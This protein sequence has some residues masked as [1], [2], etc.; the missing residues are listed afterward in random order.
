MKGRSVLKHLRRIGGAIA[1]VQ[2]TRRSCRAEHEV[3]NLACGSAEPQTRFAY[4][5]VSLSRQPF[6]KFKLH[7]C[8][9]AAALMQTSTSL[10]QREV[11]MIT[12]D[13]SSRQPRADNYSNEGV[14]FFAFWR[15]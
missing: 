3:T 4:T 14:F 8:F 15:Q 13:L 6:S 9:F 5:S 10:R 7:D 11:T 1:I 2:L 12:F